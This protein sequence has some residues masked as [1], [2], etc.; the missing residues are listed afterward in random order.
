MCNVPPIN[1]VRR[2]EDLGQ[3]P[4]KVVE[5]FAID[6]NG[7]VILIRIRVALLG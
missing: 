6:W 4:Y 5:L 7:Y 2:F 1:I 3:L